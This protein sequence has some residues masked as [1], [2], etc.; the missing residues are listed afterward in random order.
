MLVRFTM[1]DTMYTELA[2]VVE[3]KYQT[4]EERV[5]AVR[6]KLSGWRENGTL[7]VRTP[8]RRT[9][10]PIRN[11]NRGGDAAGPTSNNE[12]KAASA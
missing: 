11:P 6:E 9:G 10:V 2:I 8:Y 7:K 12:F 5:E 1:T 3:A 4:N